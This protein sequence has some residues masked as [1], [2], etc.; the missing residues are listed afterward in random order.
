MD[1]FDYVIVGAGTAGCLLANRLTEDGRVTVCL[2][3]AGPP[4]RNFYLHLPAG[5][6]KVGYNPAYTWPF[7]TEP[8]EGTAGRRIL[9]T[10]GRTLGGSSAINGFNYTRGQPADYDAWSGMGNP[11]WGYADVLP[12]FKRT[13]RR[14]GQL[15]PRYRGQ[16]G[17]LPI[18]DCDWRHPLCDAFIE[19]AAS[20]GIPRHTDY[21]AER[22]TSTGYYQRWIENGWRV[23]AARAFLRP[24]MSRAN[25]DVRTNAHA[26]SILLEGRRA[27]GVE[28]ASGPGAAG[29][30]VRAR[31]E[32]ILAAGA[33]NTPKLMQISGIGPASLLNGLGIGVKVDLRGVGENLRDHMMVRSI[34]QVK[35][36]ETL[37]SA[38]RGWR[39]LRE[40][41]KWALKRPSI[42]AISPSVAYAFCRADLS[43]GNPDLQ[44]HF[45]PGSYASGIAGKLDAFPG[46]TLG[47]YQ[48]RPTSSGHVRACSSNPFDDPIVQPN[49]LATEEDRR[50]VV[51]AI[52]LTRRFLRTPA[53]LAYHE[54]EVSPSASASS[55][56]ELLDYARH[57]GGTAWHLMGTCRMGPATDPMSVVD[58]QLRVIGMEGLRVADASIMPT[59][60]S[61]N[62]GAPTMMI[63]EKAADLIRGKTTYGGASI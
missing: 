41:A 31:K 53:L 61:G 10:Q 59:M 47:F 62:T 52:R 54:R 35:G 63:A 57:N 4:D 39:L 46:M 19:G 22:Q 2:L 20:T 45:S 36:V 7:R 24:A 18:T 1:V 6:I 14:I 17:L 44:F 25:L 26:T 33:A 37:N 43:A 56:Q 27:T 58:A 40:I 30:Q 12:Y 42:L 28:Y 13:E 21:N 48:L 3:E 50:L 23:S 34:V 38:A 60:P 49:Y 51:A 32:V 5:F 11:G 15:D 8:S 16:D 55:D 29:S 9:T